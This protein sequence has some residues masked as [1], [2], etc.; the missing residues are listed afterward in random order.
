MDNNLPAPSSPTVKIYHLRKALTDQQTEQLKTTFLQSDSYDLLVQEDADGYDINGDMLFR[1][2]KNAIPFEVLK[3]GYESF[4]DSIEWTDGRGAASGYTGKRKR[5][6]GSD[7]KVNVGLHVESG[8]VGFMDSSAMI[9]YCRKTAFAKK[10]F[11]KFTAGIPFV[12]C[13]DK[14]YKELCPEQYARQI[15]IARGTDANYRIGNTSFTTVTVNRNFQTA[16]HKDSGD[17]QDGFGNL[18]I[19]REGDTWSGSYFTLPQYRV[20]IDM[21][22]CD[23]L[24]VDVHKWHGNTPFVNH[25]PEAGDLRIAFVM[26]YR[27]YMYKCKAP[28][29]EL[30]RVKME[31]GGF[32]RL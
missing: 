30:E 28:A 18:C 7:S 6:D 3:L 11:D 20:A 24:F 13:V 15:A 27:E 21:Q 10:Y 9:R 19:Y 31:Q 14:L 2:R 22:N 17:Y 26:Y 5:P 25:N 1:F 23:M 8:N 4:K 32:L 12:E 16:V 29:E